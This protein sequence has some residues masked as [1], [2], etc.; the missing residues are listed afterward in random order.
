MIDKTDIC[1]LCN[2]NNNLKWIHEFVLCK[3][4]THTTYNGAFKNT[5]TKYELINNLK[6]IM[7]SD[8]R[9]SIINKQKKRN[10]MAQ[11]SIRIIMIVIAVFFLFIAIEISYHILWVVFGCLFIALISHTIEPEV[12]WKDKIN[13]EAKKEA[14]KILSKLYIK[15]FQKYYQ[16]APDGQ[17]YKEKVLRSFFDNESLE[18]LT[19]AEWNKM[20]KI[21]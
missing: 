11:Q 13:I 14:E 1:V 16:L 18:I 20:K 10:K 2:S 8:C 17:I 9:Q 15:D 21:Q 3:T 6:I 5:T 4:F 12:S 7:C 19:I